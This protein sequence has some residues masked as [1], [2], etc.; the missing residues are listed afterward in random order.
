MCAHIY[1]LSMG[2]NHCVQG[3]LVCAKVYSKVD[4]V[5]WLHIAD[6][7][8]DVLLWR[9]FYQEANVF[10]FTMQTICQFYFNS[11]MEKRLFLWGSEAS[12][13]D[14][15][16]RQALTKTHQEYILHCAYL[17]TAFFPRQQ[18]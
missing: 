10:A 9:K 12:Q 6:N 2:R 13:I 3:Q 5:F 7:Y 11:Q 1:V 18:H 4:Y 16:C 15:T 17:F 14:M 8:E